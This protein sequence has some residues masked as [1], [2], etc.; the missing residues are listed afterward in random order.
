MDWQRSGMPPMAAKAGAQ[1]K[2]IHHSV[3]RNGSKL[4]ETR[5]KP[6]FVLYAMGGEE[7]QHSCA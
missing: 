1:K 4:S 2:M 3:T 6:R 7:E 5:H